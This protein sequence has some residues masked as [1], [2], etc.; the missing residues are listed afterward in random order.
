[1]NVKNFLKPLNED[2]A[3]KH[4]ASP[5][6]TFLEKGGAWDST[7]LYAKTIK[8][9]NGNIVVELTEEYTRLH[10]DKEDIPSDGNT[11]TIDN[12]SSIELLD[13]S[14]SDL[15]FVYRYSLSDE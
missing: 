12:F 5:V 7:P 9:E 14:V 13:V 15:E 6:V 11:L 4:W 8:N 3:K 10:Q 2:W 1:M